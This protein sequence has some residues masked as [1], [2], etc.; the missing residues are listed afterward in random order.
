M[1]KLTEWEDEVNGVYIAA[2]HICGMYRIKP[3][4]KHFGGY[5]G[6]FHTK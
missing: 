1:L 4:A 3:S 2:K 5:T 6:S